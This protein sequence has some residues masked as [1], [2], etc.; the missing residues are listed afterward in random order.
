MTYAIIESGGKQYRV[1]PGKVIDIEL[2]E[3]QEGDVTFKEVLFV[4]GGST[5]V[6]LPFVKGAVVKGKILGPVRGPKVVSYKYK[7][8][9][10]YRRKVGH[11]QD[12]LRVEITGIEG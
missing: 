6:G 2:L 1:E 10:N 12:Y 3:A 5:Q 9:K 7:K 4:H 8:R 11:R